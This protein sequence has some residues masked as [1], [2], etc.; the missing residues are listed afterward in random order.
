MRGVPK[1]YCGHYHSVCTEKH[2]WLV[3]SPGGERVIVWQSELV[4]WWTRDRE[5]WGKPN[6]RAGKP[7]TIEDE[8]VLRR[9][10]EADR[11]WSKRIE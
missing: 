9:R 1:D 3:K 4:R 2:R 5:N 10:E 8:A 11:L 6:G 7:L